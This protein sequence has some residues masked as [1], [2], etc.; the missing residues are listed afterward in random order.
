MVKFSNLAF[1]FKRCKQIFH[2]QFTGYY[3]SSDLK[4]SNQS[5][6]LNMS[7]IYKSTQI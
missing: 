4:D 6:E 1:R 7:D 3:K 2:N 5:V